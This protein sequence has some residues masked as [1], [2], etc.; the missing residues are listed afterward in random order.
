MTVPKLAR[1]SFDGVA[2]V[3]TEAVEAGAFPG[4]V[5]LVAQGGDVRYHEAFG[6]RRLVPERAPL[7]ADTVFDLSS[8]TKPLATTTMLM[9]LAREGKLRPEDRVT[10]FV[11]NFGAH[12]KFGVTVRHLLAHCSG[13]PA[14][15]PFYRDI[16]R[17]AHGRPNHLASRGAREF[18]YE[19]IHRE[20]LEYPTGA[21]SVY[22]DL[23]F[24]LLGELIELVAQAPLDRVC[25]ER[26]FRPLGLRATGFVDLGRLRR[27]NLA[28]V[29]DTIAP[30]EQCPWRQRILCGEVHDDNAWAVGGVAG[31]AGL[32]STASDVHRLV[33][34]LRAC[35]RGD[36]P[37]L[38]AE[39]VRRFWTRDATVP[40]S[41]WALGWDTPSSTRSSAGAR[42]SPRA[43][44]H[45][46]FTGTSLWIDLERD[47][48]VVLLTNRVHP[49]RHNER[50]REVRPR[51]HDAVWDALDA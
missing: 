32:F 37:T 42:V 36:D 29:T 51:V 31:H 49:D 7:A 47:A 25:H 16:A 26:I 8:L 10:R 41:T 2:A 30:T 33:N 1:R 43:V 14:W 23:G 3:L 21:Q 28:P 17:A 27:D 50:I 40:D 9:L 38:P 35:A 34:W 18:V 13:L 6:Q 15:R 24:L 45:L 19:Q 39:V 12:G 4:A 22:S 5:I 11:Q 46:G 48:H 44:G 20:R